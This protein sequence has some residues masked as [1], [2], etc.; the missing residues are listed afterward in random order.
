MPISPTAKNTFRR[1]RVYF[2]RYNALPTSSLVCK[3]LCHAGSLCASDLVWRCGR[4]YSRK[5]TQDQ[6][7]QGCLANCPG[8]GWGR[9]RTGVLGNSGLGGRHRSWEQT[10]S[11]GHNPSL[12]RRV[13]LGRKVIESQ[14]PTAGRDPIPFPTWEGRSPERLR[15]EELALCPCS[16]CK[17]WG[18]QGW[19]WDLGPSLLHCIGKFVISLPLAPPHQLSLFCLTS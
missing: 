12:L 2:K 18:S 10:L 7:P 19:V 16:G 14:K 13:E 1:Q 5:G 11:F 4:Q 17:G 6:A 8:G 9:G 15:W 3:E